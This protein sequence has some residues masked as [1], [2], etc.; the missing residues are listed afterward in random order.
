[1]IIFT[2]SGAQGG[3]A[4]DKDIRPLKRALAR[5]RFFLVDSCGLKYSDD[6]KQGGATQAIGDCGIDYAFNGA[7]ARCHRRPRKEQ[8]NLNQ[9]IIENYDHRVRFPYLDAR[10]N[11]DFSMAS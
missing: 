4:S 11:R 8:S 10:L 1:M 7:R 6:G 9:G 3:L 5:R 2:V